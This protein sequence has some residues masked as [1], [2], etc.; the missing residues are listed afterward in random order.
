MGL[1]GIFKQQRIEGLRPS[2]LFAF[3]IYTGEQGR[4][5]QVVV[6][7]KRGTRPQVAGKLLFAYLVE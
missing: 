4:R 2:I 7:I 3:F 5:S 1:S 6:Y